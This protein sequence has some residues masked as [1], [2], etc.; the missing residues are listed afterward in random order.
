MMGIINRIWETPNHPR[1]LAAVYQYWTHLG[2]ISDE[3]LTEKGT[4]LVEDSLPLIEYF[5]AVCNELTTASYH[6]LIPSKVDFSNCNL[7]SAAYFNR[8]LKGSFWEKLKNTNG[9]LLDVGGGCGAYSKDWVRQKQKSRSAVVVDLPGTNTGEVQ[10][11]PCN[12]LVDPWAEAYKDACSVVLFSEVLYLFSPQERFAL[13][14]TAKTALKNGAA[15]VIHE[16]HPTPALSWTT[17]V[18]TEK[19]APMLSRDVAELMVSHG[20]NVRD[21][22]RTEH[23]HATI[24]G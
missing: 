16:R 22:W 5:Y 13:V 2:L 14:G 10:L 15:V 6:D 19:G 17:A 8:N 21:T 18:L 1:K 7:A 3:R 9:L 23:H 4:Q 24:W 12:I 11:Y 20:F